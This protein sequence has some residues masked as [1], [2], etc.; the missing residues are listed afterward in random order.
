M[1]LNDTS[2]SRAERENGFRVLLLHDVI[3]DTRAS[4]PVD[5]PSEVVGLVR[6]MTYENFDEEKKIVP[7]KSAFLQLLKIVD[8]VATIYD[9]HGS[10]HIFS[11]ERKKD[12]R[13]Y[14]ELL[15]QNVQSEF[16]HTQ[17]FKIAKTI[18]ANCGW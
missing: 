12:W 16:G 1:V 10:E 15:L 11:A 7:G 3:E 17:V 6:E 2:L 9:N 13:S 5:L 8:K 18:V 14:T 4:L